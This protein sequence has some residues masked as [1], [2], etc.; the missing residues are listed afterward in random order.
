MVLISSGDRSHLSEVFL[1]CPAWEQSLA[2][3]TELFWI[4]I[5]NTGLDTLEG[6]KG[7]QIDYREIID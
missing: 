4:V 1:L 2:G 7:G 3:T 6:K 5:L